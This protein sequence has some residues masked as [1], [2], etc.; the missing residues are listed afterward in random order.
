MIYLSI[1]LTSPIIIEIDILVYVLDAIAGH[2]ENGEYEGL[3]VRGLYP[4]AIAVFHVL[5]F[6][7]HEN[8]YWECAHV[9][10][11]LADES[12]IFVF[13]LCDVVRTGITLLEVV[14]VEMA[15]EMIGVC[16]C[17]FFGLINCV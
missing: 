3:V 10:E 1:I 15:I 12:V 11:F 13:D 17:W 5:L 6:D 8:A 2:L 7:A 9:A 4:I 16:D 14:L